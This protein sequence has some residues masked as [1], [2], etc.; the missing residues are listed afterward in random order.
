M[1]WLRR[2]YGAHPIHLLLMLACFSVAGYALTRIHAQGGISRIVLWFAAVLILHDLIGWPLY[3]WA[4]RILLRLS[5][6][7]RPDRS[8]S[9]PWINHVRIPLFL[10]GILLLISFPLVFRLSAADYASL[11]GTSESGYFG[12]WLLVTGLF[13]ETRKPRPRDGPGIARA[14]RLRLAA[15]A[16]PACWPR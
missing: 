16:R 5:P 2:H 10:S 14:G 12:H 8:A 6:R 15:V 13:F 9:V 11:S 7:P 4:D 3:T 1:R